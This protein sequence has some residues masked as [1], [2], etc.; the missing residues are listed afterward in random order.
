[1]HVYKLFSF[2]VS[3]VAVCI[4][5]TGVG[6]L[7]HTVGAVPVNSTAIMV[8]WSL[9]GHVTAVTVTALPLTGDKVPRF[10]SVRSVYMWCVHILL[11][12][13]ICSDVCVR[14]QS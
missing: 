3:N 11:S 14:T 7:L 12:A 6:V 4:H 10:T 9:A 1:M 8:T 2:H 5:C 13:S